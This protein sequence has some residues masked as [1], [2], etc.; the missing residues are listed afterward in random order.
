M[1]VTE[2]TL[3]GNNLYINGR[4]IEF[5]NG[6]ALLVRDKVEFT[7]QMIAQ[8]H[9]LKE[10]EDLSQLAYKY[11]GSIVKDPSKYWWLIADANDAIINPLDL[12]H[13]VGY[14]LAIPDVRKALLLIQ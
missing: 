4:I 7:R 10:N 1:E 11:Y 9:T 3:Q 5:E 6:D 14:K 12:T 8:Y 13:L 2:L